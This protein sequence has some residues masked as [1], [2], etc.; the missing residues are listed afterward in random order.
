MKP[1]LQC[2]MLV[3]LIL[4]TQVDAKI[5]EPVLVSSIETVVIKTG[6]VRAL[7]GELNS[8]ELNISVPLKTD[9][10]MPVYSVKTINDHE[11]NTI[12]TVKSDS[13]QNPFTYAISSDVLTK[14]RVTD[15][16]P[17]AYTVPDE[18]EIYA[19]PSE[20]IQS[21]NNAIREM[22]EGI[23]ENSSN[24]F[25]KLAKIAIWVHEHITYDES[26]SGK[27]KD[28]IWTF[29]KR[30]GVCAEYTTLFIAMARSIGIPS[31]YISGYSYTKDSGWMGHAWAEAYIGE[32]VPFDPTWMEAGHLDATHIHVFSMAS[33]KPENN[34]FVYMSQGSKLEW[35][36]S[37]TLGS[38]I[39]EVTVKKSQ[40]TAPDDTY[41]LKSGAS[42]IEFGEETVVYA[43]VMSNDYRVVDLN[44]VTCSGVGSL[45]I[46]EPERFSILEPGEERIVV[47]LVKAPDTLSG[48]Y[49]YKC[50]MVLNSQYLAE[51]SK[52][53][54]MLQNV[55][56]VHLRAW[57]EK[58]SVE[59]GE[60]Q[61]VFFSASNYPPGAEISI[62]ADDEMYVFSASSVARSITLSPESLGRKTV[63]VFSNYGGVERLRYDVVN[64][65]EVSIEEI[66]VSENLIE[67]GDIDL[68]FVLR[69]NS[70]YSRNIGLA[71]EYGLD[72]HS[73]QLKLSEKEEFK[74]TF[75]GVKAGTDIIII[76][77]NG[78]GI[79]MERKVTVTVDPKPHVDVLTSFSKGERITNVTFSLLK[80]GDPIN[81]I[82]YLD[83][84][85][86]PLTSG[87]GTIG[88]VAGT[89]SIKTVWY[90][91]YGTEYSSVEDL[92]VPSRATVS[93][94]H[95][96]YEPCRTSLFI[97]SVLFLFAAWRKSD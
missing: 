4:S 36:G 52:S 44:L 11:G 92:N 94:G 14:A 9:W 79:D 72:K 41:I 55:Q 80:T 69:S 10:Q 23:T 90:D 8:V 18:L 96:S 65:K 13:P 12:A 28:A 76:G 5:G 31:R 70:K 20:N 68:S 51:S 39:K 2:L 93:W 35:M 63:W 88:L 81:I 1:S 84:E 57:L 42:Q 47:W 7:G 56:K 54:T 32:W 59:L 6:T 25:E 74:F 60:R 3:L 24:Q 53:I 66:S 38:A 87:E 45:I 34:V 17:D 71:V 89:Y 62:I 16:L 77:V 40:S 82:I 97:M 49:S 26:L 61:T 46:E 37:G 64:T 22:A 67:G 83:G 50:P 73:M 85:I 86:T 95:E 19:L 33:H 29:S 43:K 21:D 78:E 27:E 91:G 15:S 30:R 48:G 75:S 58:S